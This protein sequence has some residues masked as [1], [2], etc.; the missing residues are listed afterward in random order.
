VR[1]SGQGKKESFGRGVRED[2]DIGIR[3]FLS[4]IH[5]VTAW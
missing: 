3:R 4:N 5:V 1:T 2:S